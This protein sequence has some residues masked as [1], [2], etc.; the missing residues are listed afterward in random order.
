[1]A[2]YAPT[3]AQREVLFEM[4]RTWEMLAGQLARYERLKN[5]EARAQ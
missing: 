4:A 2:R 3:A 5:E 1:V